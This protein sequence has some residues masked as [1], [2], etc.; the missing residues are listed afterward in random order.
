MRSA[1]EH[2]TT[3]EFEPVMADAPP[4]GWIVTESRGW[5]SGSRHVAEG[6]A[7]QSMADLAERHSLSWPRILRQDDQ[8]ISKYCVLR[9]KLDFRLEG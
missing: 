2:A 3:S 5:P 6:L 4:G 9:L 8:L 1:S 7:A